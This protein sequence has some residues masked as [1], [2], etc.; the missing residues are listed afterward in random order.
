MYKKV[1][2]R[3]T[4]VLLS[5]IFLGVLVGAA[6]AVT[7]FNMTA[8]TTTLTMP[9]ATVVP[10]WGFALDSTDIGGVVTPGDGLVKVPGDPLVV[11]P[12]ETIVIISLTNNLPEPVSLNILGQ[13]LTPAGGPVWTAGTSDAVV[14]TG[15][16][17]VGDTTARVRSFAHET[18]PGGTVS[19]T[20]A[21]FKPGSYLLLSGTNP[22]KQVQMGL[23]A[24]VTQDVAAG[25]AYTGASYTKELVLVYS[26]VDPEMHEAVAGGYYGA[27][28]INP[29]P[30]GKVAIP[31]SL[32]R[33]A[34]YFLIN[35]MAYEPGGGLD[36]VN[37]GI[38]VGTDDRVLLRLL[39]AGYETHVP[40]ILNMYMRLL[41]EDG[42]PLSYSRERYG[43]SLPAAK[44]ADV[45]VKPTI[46]GTF[47]LYD[48]M[49]N[50]TN[51]GDGAPGG[52]LSYLNIAL[53]DTDGDTVVDNLDNCTLV[54]NPAQ[55]DT[56]GDNFGN[57][58]DTDLNN[59]GTT[60]GTDVL[61]LRG[62]FLTADPDADFNGDNIVN[63]GDILILRDF[64]LQPPGPS[65]LV[66]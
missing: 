46:A 37:A 65:G 3:F 22:A 17:P 19:Y 5:L 33:D 41:A 55:R 36:P 27:N 30:V 29:P 45:I 34:K 43:I 8:G 12:G 11:P 54:P 52:M 53:V 62:V 16:R 20:W 66:P 50:L 51:A 31:S 13:M 1:L 58:C 47:P 61:V 14:S 60:N 6:N 4:G 2:K 59:D 57:Y 35:G 24:A 7:T 38:P 49:L 64:F 40:Q 15:S 10:M 63:G 44:T 18:P 39:N 25:V 56:D 42:N 48:A 32:H 21:N 28:P 26:E 9:D 23:Y